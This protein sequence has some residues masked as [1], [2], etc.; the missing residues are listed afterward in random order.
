EEHAAFHRASTNR[1]SHQ[2]FNRKCRKVNGQKC[3]CISHK[4][5]QTTQR[6]ENAT[7][8][9]RVKGGEKA[10]VKGRSATTDKRLNGDASKTKPSLL[11]GQYKFT[12]SVCS[13]NKIKYKQDRKDS[14]KTNQNM[15]KFH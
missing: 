9:L 3:G 2:P 8:Q 6:A 15:V 13:N 12:Y 10:R 14:Y 4:K 1:T 11:K 5:I 7:K